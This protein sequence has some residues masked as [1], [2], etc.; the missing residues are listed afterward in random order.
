MKI[1]NNYVSNSS[2]SSFILE[3]IPALASLTSADWNEMLKGLYN[4]YEKTMKR[5]RR[6]LET[7]LNH[8]TRIFAQR[9]M[10]LS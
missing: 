6:S 2:S 7:F 4:N 3:D 10:A 8:G 5:R 9:S 1:R